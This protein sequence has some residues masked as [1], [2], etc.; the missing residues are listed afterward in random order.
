MHRRACA[1]PDY[2]LRASYVAPL[3]RQAAC[4][5][6]LGNTAPRGIAEEWN[7]AVHTD[8]AIAAILVSYPQKTIVVLDIIPLR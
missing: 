1:P 5:D 6:P 3:T 2:I 7:R 4:H 8:D